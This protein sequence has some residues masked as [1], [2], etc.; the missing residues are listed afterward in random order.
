[1]EDDSK[2]STFVDWAQCGSDRFRSG[3]F[4]VLQCANKKLERFMIRHTQLFCFQVRHGIQLINPR[5][6]TAFSCSC[7]DLYYSFVE[8]VALKTTFQAWNVTLNVYYS[9]LG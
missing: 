1:M 4:V 3:R 8:R 5:I 7:L 9:C 6:F 2:D